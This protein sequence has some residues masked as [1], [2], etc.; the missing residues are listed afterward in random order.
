MEIVKLSGYNTTFT[1]ISAILI[2]PMKKTLKIPAFHIVIFFIT[3]SSSL[4]IMGTYLTHP[5][6]FGNFNQHFL[7]AKMFGVPQELQ[8]K[9]IK[10]LYTDNQNT[11]WDG[12]FYYYISNDL[13]GLE[14]TSQHVDS[15]AYR[16]QRIG[17]PLLAKILSIVTFQHWVSPLTYYLTTLLLI[18]AASVTG[19][20]FFRERKISP[21]WILFWSLGI[22]TQ[23]TLLNGLPDAAADS[24]LIMSLVCLMRKRYSWYAL[25]ASLAALS[26]EVYIL[27]PGFIF[28]ADT[29]SLQSFKSFHYLKNDINHKL[30]QST[31]W[32]LLIPLC[33]FIIWQVYIRLHFGSPVLQ[34]GT[35][36]DGPFYSAWH[37]MILGLKNQ[38]PIVGAGIY[39]YREATGIILFITLLGICLAKLFILLKS[40]NGINSKNNTIGLSLGFIS[41]IILYFFF[42]PVVMMHYTGYM[43]AGTI[44]YFV[45]FFIM[46]L[47]ASNQ[48][49]STLLKKWI[50]RILL[51]LVIFAGLFFDRHF[52]EDHILST[53]TPNPYSTSQSITYVSQEPACMKHF[54]AQITILSNKN[55]LPKTLFNRLFISQYRI[56]NVKVTNTGQESFSPYPGKGTVNLS[57][58]WVD[59]ENPTNVIID[60]MRTPLPQT[61]KPGESI[62]LPMMVAFPRK[63]GKYILKL[64]LVQEGCAWFYIA[65]SKSSTDITYI[66]S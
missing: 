44:F 2:N 49:E 13:L 17:L 46:A 38:H 54:D 37:F 45:F 27:I 5:L 19:A 50:N 15:D 41:I 58:H 6:L 29:V 30:K 16:Y 60:G 52:L 55:L 10:V 24:L 20:S 63:S 11:G 61:L 1:I 43:K 57:Y 28:L 12:Q 47:N 64:S 59:A 62:I 8:E 40:N 9:G 65:N 4:A 51:V 14:D 56:I 48:S 23:L 34:S 32:L 53:P 22:G 33:V 18:L 7:P 31:F 3:L 26:R 35:T 39:S 42:G 66:I 21:Y 25:T 36:L